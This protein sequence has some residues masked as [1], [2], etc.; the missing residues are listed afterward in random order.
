MKL[1]AI[2]TSTELASVALLTGDELLSKNQQGQKSHAQHLLSMID[3]LI[4]EA[5]ICL[6]NLDGII[7]G[8]GPG[9]FTGLRI[10]CSVAK[11]LAY[12]HDLGLIPVSTLA[13]I[14]WSARN[15]LKNTNLPVLAIIDARMNELYW[16]YSCD[17]NDFGVDAV[18]PAGAIVV[19]ETNA[20]VLAGVGIDAYQTDLSADLK[21]RISIALPIIPEASAMISLAQETKITA[22]S[23]AKAQPIYVRN[24]VTQGASRG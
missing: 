17:Q 3:A 21:S 8:C 19:P 11:G 10:A 13:T 12:A 7:F 20:F 5:D 18:S 24:Q 1:L 16:C 2:D 4:K 6:Q 9:S 23:A 15:Q 14:V 22:I